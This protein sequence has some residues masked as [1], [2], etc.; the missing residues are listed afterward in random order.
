MKRAATI[1]T[2]HPIL[3]AAGD[4]GNALIAKINFPA[5][6]AVDPQPLLS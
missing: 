6:A 3:N 4:G 1:V 2:F 5:K